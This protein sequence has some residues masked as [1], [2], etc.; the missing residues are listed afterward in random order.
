MENFLSTDQI[1]SGFLLVISNIAILLPIYSTIKRNL[2][3]EFII[4]SIMAIMSAIYHFCQVEFYCF[5]DFNILQSLDHTFVFNVIIWFIFW[6]IDINLNWLIIIFFI[7]QPIT[8]LIFL[9]HLNERWS[10][11]YIIIIILYLVSIFLFILKNKIIL[12]NIPYL[13]ISVIFFIIGLVLHLIAGDP[14]LYTNYAWLHFIW[15]I[16]AMISIYF[17]IESKYE[18]TNKNYKF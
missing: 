15:H 18:F 1:I 9:N 5:F 14:S 12:K 13:F 16:F 7:F 3:P 6:F 4:L 11:L 2:L 8:L 10:T 17:L